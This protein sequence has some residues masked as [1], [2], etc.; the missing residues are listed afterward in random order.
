MA[1]FST[2][3]EGNVNLRLGSGSYGPFP[4]DDDLTYLWLEYDASQ[5]T[6]PAAV[7][8]VEVSISIDGGPFR[9]WRRFG[10]HGRTF[11]PRIPK[12]FAGGD[13]RGFEGKNRRVQI[14]YVVEGARFRTTV[15]AIGE[16]RALDG[17]R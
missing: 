17:L 16:V 12:N 10:A 6:D 14:T 9:L 1:G 13:L 8:H 3:L 11:D 7:I 4:I 5:W 2:E 15:R